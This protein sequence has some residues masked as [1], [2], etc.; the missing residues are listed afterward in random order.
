MIQRETELGRGRAEIRQVP[1][2]Q[3]CCADLSKIGAPVFDCRTPNNLDTFP[4]PVIWPANVVRLGSSPKEVSDAQ[5][6]DLIW[7]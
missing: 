3:P 1:D 5:I 7:R 6:P 4:A 2:Q